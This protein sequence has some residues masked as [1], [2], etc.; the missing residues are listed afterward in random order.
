[1]SDFVE[2][3]TDGACSGNPGPGG[4][5]ALLRFKGVE[6][7]ISG[8]EAW[9]TNNR[10]EMTAAVMAL[11]SLT[12]PC[13]V[14][15]TTDSQYMMKGITQWIKKWKQRG[16]QTV[17]KKPVKNADL[18]CRLDEAASR[19]KVDWQWVRGHANHEENEEVDALARQAMEEWRHKRT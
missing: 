2:I 8:G 11:E 7:T 9:T 12:R 18:W 15:L 1:M 17:D 16:W 19:H 3:F 4:W 14:R 5:A 10:M 13:T 6:K